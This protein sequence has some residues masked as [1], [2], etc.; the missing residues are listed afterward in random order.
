MIIFSVLPIMHQVIFRASFQVVAALLLLLL[1]LQGDDCWCY[2]FKVGDVDCWGLPPPSNPLVYSSWSQT[3]RFRLG[4]TLLFLYPRSQDSVM[5]VTE[6]AFN[7][8]SLADPI[9]KLDD[10]NSLFKLTTPGNYYFTSG[11]P[12]H[13]EKN[14]K[15][16]V[17]VPSLNNGTFFPPAVDFA[18][19]PA[20]SQSY[21]TVFGPAPTQ[22]PSGNPAAAVTA[23][24]SVFSAALLLGV[25]LP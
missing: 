10:G 11:V 24:G 3:H 6:R 14:Q 16:A 17:A 19:P 20:G 5:Q 1:L 4:D 21:L 25:A 18:G 9:L 15:L 12:G 8:C 22:G 13:C 23:M 7:S 2:Q